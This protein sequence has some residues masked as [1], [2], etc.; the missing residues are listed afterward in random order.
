MTLTR[1]VALV[2]SLLAGAG[3]ATAQEPIAMGDLFSLDSKVM[4]EARNV[5][6]WTPPGYVGAAASFPVLY[7]TDAERQFG[8]TVTTVEFLP[9]TG[10]CRR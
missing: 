5:I 3:A 9:E 10:V 7:L 8:H 6:V 4:G 1:I 2:V